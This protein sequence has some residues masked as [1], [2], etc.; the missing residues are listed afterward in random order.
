MKWSKLCRTKHDEGMGFREL[1]NLSDTLLAKKVWR[2]MSNQDSLFY[3]FFKA[4][5]F[6]HGIIFYAKNNTRF[7]AWKS[8][9]KGVKWRIG[10]GSSIKIL[11]NSWLPDS[12]H[13]R[14]PSHLG[15][16][17]LEALVASLID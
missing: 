8:M 1:K 9:L 7:F 4:K 16:H 14:V 10:N 5:F 13:G 11:P 17:N 3:K 6:P 12:R 2:L 15:D